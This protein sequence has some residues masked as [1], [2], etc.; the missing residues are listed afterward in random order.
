MIRLKI[1]KEA[2]KHGIVTLY[3]D[4]NIEIDEEL[5]NQILL[6]TPCYDLAVSKD[7]ELI[8]LEC[9]LEDVEK[10]NPNL[11]KGVYSFEN[12][13][14]IMFFEVIENIKDKI[15]PAIVWFTLLTR[16][17]NFRRFPATFQKISLFF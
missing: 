9:D 6:K 12:K 5:S 16:L 14:N 17:R 10:L 11:F 13:E 15:F 3:T 2:L 1:D 8:E 4:E 7:G